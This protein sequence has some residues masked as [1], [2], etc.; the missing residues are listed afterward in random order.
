[1]DLDSPASG[2][3]EDISG[4]TIGARERCQADET[5]GHTVQRSG[6][7]VGSAAFVTV[8]I[9]DPPSGNTV[10]RE[11]FYGLRAGQNTGQALMA[12]SFVQAKA[13]RMFVNRPS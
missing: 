1:M 13:F 2:Q 10:G 3:N 11:S 9:P 6:D 5:K 12:W 4:P 8:R 7:V